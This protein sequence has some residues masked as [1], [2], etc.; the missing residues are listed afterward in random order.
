MATWREGAFELLIYLRPRE[1]FP[2]RLAPECCSAKRCAMGRRQNRT[3]LVAPLSFRA[4]R[5]IRG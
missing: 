5:A 2:A 1:R 4:I 3:P